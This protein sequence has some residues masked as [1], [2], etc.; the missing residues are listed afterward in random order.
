MAY[1][2]LPTARQILSK[3]AI[4]LYRLGGSQGRAT[5]FV[6]YN[7]SVMQLDEDRFSYAN[8]AGS[9]DVYILVEDALPIARCQPI[10]RPAEPEQTDAALLD[11]R[12]P[13]RTRKKA[14]AF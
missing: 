6:N 8:A 10:G 5:A 4:K 14:T 12:I 13:E 3:A 2:S 7:P 1:S 9:N 11:S